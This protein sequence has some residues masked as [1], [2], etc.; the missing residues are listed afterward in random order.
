MFMDKGLK[1][2]RK[3]TSADFALDDRFISSVLKPDEQATGFFKQLKD[4]YPHLE[5]PMNDARK[6]ISSFEAPSEIINDEIKDRIWK[7]VMEE[8]KDAPVIHIDSRRKYWWAAA[9]ILFSVIASFSAYYFLN[10]QDGT[11]NEVSQ[12]KN[13]PAND[14][15]PG[16]NK[17]IL[18]LADGSTII[19]DSVNNGTLSHQG[20][21][22][23]VKVDDGKL[24]YDKG[25]AVGKIMYNTITTPRGGQYQLVLADG[26]KV[27]LNAQ[28]TLRFPVSFNSD[29]RK[30]FLNGEA[31]FEVT[32]N[33]NKPFRVAIEK[34]IVE[35]LGTDFN[36]NSYRDED[37]MAVTLL[38]GS[39]KLHTQNISRVLSP[40]DQ[41]LVG[42]ESS[43]IRI[44]KNVN[45][46][47]VVAWKNGLFDFN[48]EDL[49]AIMRKISRWYKADIVFNG[50]THTGHYT[51]AIRKSA[52]INEVL[53][54]L[55]VA[56][57]VNFSVIGNKIIVN[58]K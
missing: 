28:T 54:M 32:K 26:S 33:K 1:K 18:T 41:A 27:W 55:E 13:K 4:L 51:G 12:V 22:T 45:V 11:I 50:T 53:K 58:E 23:V 7:K 35:V 44:R 34:D 14:I 57:D 5:K 2:Y 17:A 25:N 8:T 47:A 36:I 21:V 48:N 49:P 38:E 6:I 31:Y 20:N 30:V 56:G 46:D 3:F 15:T 24:A 19:L 42:N 10:R 40:G 43:Q 16:G 29:E 52:T 39:V 37:A 9:A